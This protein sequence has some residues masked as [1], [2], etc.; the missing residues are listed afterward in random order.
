MEYERWTEHNFPIEYKAIE[1]HKYT[2]IAKLRVEGISS[3][4]D[5][6]VRTYSETDM[7]FKNYT[8]I[9]VIRLPANAGSLEK[10]TYDEGV[11]LNSQEQVFAGREYHRFH[12]KAGE[13]YLVDSKLKLGYDRLPWRI[14]R[15]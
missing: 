1:K 5:I 10:E 4:Q 8:R 7:Y 13:R 3:G 12:H 14:Q 6:I 11:Y 2:L 9:R 15:A